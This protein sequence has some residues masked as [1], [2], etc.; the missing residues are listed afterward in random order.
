MI[1]QDRFG[2]SGQAQEARICDGQ[3]WAWYESAQLTVCLIVTFSLTVTWVIVLRSIFS[4]LNVSRFSPASARY[5]CVR[6]PAA[7]Y[8]LPQP[9]I[10]PGAV[11]FRG[12]YPR[13]PLHYGL[14]LDQLIN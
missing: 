4:Q 12:M 6:F 8:I 14:R 10:G 2:P 5:D 1:S 13:H 9:A 7:P 11:L 3:A